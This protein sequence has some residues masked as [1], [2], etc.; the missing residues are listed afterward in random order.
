MRL[1][2]LIA[3][4]CATQTTAQEQPPGAPAPS[5]LPASAPAPSQ[6]VSVIERNGTCSFVYT[7]PRYYR[8]TAEVTLQGV[9][10]NEVLLN[11]AFI[12]LLRSELG[13]APCQLSMTQGSNCTSGTQQLPCSDPV[14]NCGNGT[15][16]SEDVYIAV[17]QG[18]CENLTANNTLVCNTIAANPSISQAVVSGL[19]RPACISGTPQATQELPVACNSYTLSVDAADKA[20]A[21]AIASALG[22]T[23]V[24][25]TLS[26]SL[27]QFSEGPGLQFLVVD[28]K[29]ESEVGYGFF[30]PPPPPLKVIEPAETASKNTTATAMGA[31]GTLVYG[32]WSPCLPACGDG[33]STRTVSCFAPDGTLLSILSCPNGASAQTYQSCSYVFLF[34][35]TNTRNIILY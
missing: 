34:L 1:I 21:L 25:S 26:N 29:I 31:A 24:Q 17:R 30:P 20:A 28:T 23:T 9:R 4:L 27:S 35:L 22:N 18:N 32:P 14:F 11:D 6:E 33:F 12:R 8:V 19:C 16:I 13:V 7:S 2:I 3:F 10:T 15:M 5:P